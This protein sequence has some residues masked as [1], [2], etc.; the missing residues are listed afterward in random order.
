MDV[1]EFRDA[2]E[3]RSWL[4]IQHAQHSE[5]WLRIAKRHAALELI[6]IDDAGD[7]GLC[8]GWIDGQRKAYDELSFVQ[9][10]SPRRAKSPWS[11]INVDR[12]E[13]LLEAGRMHPAGLA[14]VELAKA[15]GRWSGAYAPQRTAEPPAQLLASLALNP[16][17]LSTFETLPR[18]ERFLLMLPLLKAYTPQSKE[19]ALAR[20][21]EALSRP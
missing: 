13:S 15:D 10:Y 9:R 4:E 16:A 2:S 19:R 7:V 12:V 21:M 14:E 18:S 20:I 5:A 17:A 8:F 3:W 11:Q 1:L 6:T